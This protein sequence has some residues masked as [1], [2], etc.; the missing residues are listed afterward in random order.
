MKKLPLVLGAVI[1][2]VAGGV[3]GIYSNG[4][5]T[6]ADNSNTSEVPN[7]PQTLEVLST[8]EAINKSGLGDKLKNSLENLPFESTAN[9]GVVDH[10]Q[11]GDKTIKHLRLNYQSKHGAELTLSVFES[12]LNMVLPNELEEKI[13]RTS[14]EL[15]W[16]GEAEY[17]KI[18]N[19]SSVNWEKDGLSYVINFSNEEKILNN[20]KEENAEAKISNFLKQNFK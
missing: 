10:I 13:V 15:P 8:Q 7:E 18:G 16:G 11:D 12:D 6:F 19:S 20:I 5:T 1:C 17:T 3:S 14:L 9:Y 4:S 2:I